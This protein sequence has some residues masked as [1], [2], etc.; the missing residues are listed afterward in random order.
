MKR[1]SLWLAGFLLALLAAAGGAAWVVVR[2]GV[3]A[4]DEPTRLAAIAAA[5]SSIEGAGFTIVAE[6]DSEVHGPKGN[7]ERFLFARG[8]LAVPRG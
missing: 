7:V 2:H 6:A 1:A 5:R 4:R 3:S 8:V